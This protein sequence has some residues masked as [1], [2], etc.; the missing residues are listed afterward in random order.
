A[1]RLQ[2]LHPA[3]LRTRL[4]HALPLLTGGPR[5]APL[6]LQTMRAAIAWSYDLLT[7]PQQALFRWLAIFTGGFEADAV[8]A[9]VRQLSAPGN[10]TSPAGELGAGDAGAVLDGLSVLVDQSLLQ[11]ATSPDA[12]QVRPTTRYVLLETIREYGLEQQA[13]EGEEER[14]RDAHAHWC[15]AL[16]RQANDELAGPDQAAWFDRLEQEHP[17]LRAA[18]AWLL[19][20][21]DCARGFGLISALSWFWTSRGYLREAAQWTSAFLALPT[22]ATD[23]AR[24]TVLREAASIAQWLGDTAA[25]TRHGEAALAHLQAA[26]DQ[27]GVKLT[28]R[29]LGSIA[30]NRAAL[31][32][33]AAYLA[34]SDAIVL[35]TATPQDAWDAAF[36]RYLHGRLALAG[37]RLAEAIQDF[38]EA[39]A[40]FGA[41][42]NHEYVAAARSQQAAAF[43]GQGDLDQARQAYRDGLAHAAAVS[44]P[45]W[46]AWGLSGAAY[47]ALGA[48]GRA[49][50]SRLY[51]ATRRL[52]EETGLQWP[53]DPVW[54]ALTA[55]LAPLAIAPAAVSPEAALERALR[56]AMT[57]LAGDA[58]GAE[59]PAAPLQ[60][61]TPREREVLDL[62]A[63]GL[64]DK[65]IADA[66]R[67][68]RH[69][70][71][72]HVAAIR[73][74]LAVS[75]RAAAAAVAGRH[76]ALGED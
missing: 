49:Q 54:Q 30:I 9:I 6:R 41:M 61:L 4:D 63:Q 70:A 48:G 56:E 59:P 64:T 62:L 32:E 34:A 75:T 72:N 37:G 16:A 17:N 67:I 33:A 13:A 69:T 15:L 21:Q 35:A 7:P 39:A 29:Q 11:Q 68:A 31:D 20:Q 52:V 73:R 60:H 46:M 5:D 74:K 51:A 10:L 43:V 19:A 8:A 66:L 24:G 71:V 65:E 53:D 14:L 25:A 38:D 28:L 3:D 50:A 40:A 1:A 22:A 55:Q 47:L 2:H 36:T 58:S 26:G 76:G 57:I 45:H 12:R 18:L 42:G 23:P 27:L 44:Q